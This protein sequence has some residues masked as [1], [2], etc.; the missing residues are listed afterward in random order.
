M[1]GGSPE[2]GRARYVVTHSLVD[3]EGIAGWLDWTVILGWSV[4]PLSFQVLPN[5]VAFP[6]VLSRYPAV[7]ITTSG[8][9]Q[10]QM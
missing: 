9:L 4:L 10:V 7:Y 3:L 2:L 5:P 1:S 6:C 8:H